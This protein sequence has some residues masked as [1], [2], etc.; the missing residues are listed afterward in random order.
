MVGSNQIEM[1][2]RYAYGW[3]LGNNFNGGT[4][5]RQ[6]EPD[7]FAPQQMPVPLAAPKPGYAAPIAALNMSQPAFSPDTAPQRHQFPPDPSHPHVQND[8]LGAPRMPA[9]VARFPPPPVAPIPVPSTPHPLPPTMSPILP[10]F[11]RPSKPTQTQ[12]VD[13]KWGQE[14][15]LRGNSEEKLLP[16]R[17]EMGD[18]FWR[19]FSMVA[20]E[21]SKKPNSQ[22]QR[23]DH[24]LG[25]SRIMLRWSLQRMAS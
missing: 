19:R 9:A 24:T 3:G 25:Y 4:R 21:D 8:Q 18:D 23:Y 11:A 1:L 17:G 6:A 7:Q 12:D 22:K 14:S 16:R 20:R 2:L 10:V 13:V 5:N 15:I